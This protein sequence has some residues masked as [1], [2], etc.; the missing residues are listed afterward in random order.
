MLLTGT[1]Q[2]QIDEVKKGLDTAFTIKDLGTLKYFLGIEVMRTS[3]GTFLSQKKYIKDIITSVGLEDSRAVSTPLPTNLKLSTDVGVPLSEPTVYRKLVGR[4][5]YLGITRPD[6]SYSIQHLSQFLSCPREPHLEAALHVVKYLKLTSDI[7]LFYASN[8]SLC[9]TAYSDADWNGCQFSSRSLSAYCVYLGDNLV[10]WKTKKQKTV[11]KSSAESE[12]RSMSAAASE[13]VWVAGILEDL[14]IHVPRPVTMFCDNRSAEFIAHN[15]AF[16]EKTKHIKRDYHYVREQVE[17]GFLTT[18]H[19]P[20]HLQHADL[21]TK[22][23]P[24]KQHQDLSFK[25][26]LVSQVQLEGGV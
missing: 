14:N 9:L 10:S 25:L 21:L 22:A 24:T 6:L 11:S 1:S 15:P 13:L 2:Q 5:L 16:H 4:L 8:S 19:V 12:Y 18:V 23:L 7:G 17:D 3:S 20:S 26:G